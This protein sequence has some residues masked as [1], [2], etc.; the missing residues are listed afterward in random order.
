MLGNGTSGLDSAIDSLAL[1][2]REAGLH[3]LTTDD[4]FDWLAADAGKRP[5]PQMRPV[6]EATH[7]RPAPAPSAAPAGMAPL[8]TQQPWPDD[9][10]AFLDQL[11]NDEGLP[12][13]QWGGPA[14]LPSAVLDA[15]LMTVCDAPASSSQLLDPA[16]LDLLRAVLRS[17]G[18]EPESAN[19]VPLATRSP[20]GGQMGEEMLAPLGARFRHYLGLTRPRALLVLGDRTAR[21]LGMTGGGMAPPGLQAVNFSGGTIPAIAIAH[22]ALLMRRPRAKAESWKSVRYLTGVLH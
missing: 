6:A 13:A 7:E 11:A 5:A 4:P 2:W 3:T 20:P 16:A 9:L 14:F 22:P 18:M 17:I 15:P 21:A 1:W 19:P 10:A 12:D 8:A